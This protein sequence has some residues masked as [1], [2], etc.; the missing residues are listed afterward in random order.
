[1]LA[2]QHKPAC[3]RIANRRRLKYCYVVSLT[4]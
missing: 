4:G 1:M 2:L 3:V